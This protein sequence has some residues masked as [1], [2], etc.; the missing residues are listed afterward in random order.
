MVEHL[1]YWPTDSDSLIEI[2]DWMADFTE[3]IYEWRLTIREK[4]SLSPIFPQASLL[5]ANSSLRHPFAQSTFLWAACSFSNFFCP[6]S[7]IL[8]FT[9]SVC[10]LV[11]WATSFLALLLSALLLSRASFD[12]PVPKRQKH[13]PNKPSAQTVRCFSKKNERRFTSKT[14]PWTQ[15][16]LCV[17]QMPVANPRS[18]D[19][20]RNRRGCAAQQFQHIS[21]YPSQST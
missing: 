16:F 14:S 19:A 1:V 9:S 10:P 6:L 8:R 2:H 20:A 5:W 7:L 13:V 4:T 21:Q 3:R 15:H 12:Y 11:L 18:T 17:L